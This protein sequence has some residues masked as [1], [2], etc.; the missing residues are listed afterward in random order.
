M[1]TRNYEY[2][3]GKTSNKIPVNIRLP[4]ANDSLQGNSEES[5]RAR[6]I[7][8]EELKLMQ[9]EENRRYIVIQEKFTS[10]K[11]APPPPPPTDDMYD[12]PVR[13]PRARAISSVRAA[14]APSTP[15]ARPAPSFP[16]TEPIHRAPM[17]AS[18]IKPQQSRQTSVT[19]S[20]KNVDAVVSWMAFPRDI[21]LRDRH[22]QKNYTCIVE[23]A[24]DAGKDNFALKW[25]EGTRAGSMATIDHNSVM[26]GYV[27]LKDIV[28]CQMS[29][30]DPAVLIMQIASGVRALKTSGGRSSL[31]IKF[32]SDG[33]CS[34][35]LVG[36]NT[37]QDL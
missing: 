30:R 20:A 7:R 22:T 27:F 29:P 33:E 18:P 17:M 25:Y 37:M 11:N 6:R 12:S 26:A 23:T 9:L 35:F 8:Q 16:A 4:D 15:F 34:K 5:I 14:P 1:N 36:I 10:R 19:V 2:M 32:E 21:L 24:F 13:S 28:S 3:R 31:S